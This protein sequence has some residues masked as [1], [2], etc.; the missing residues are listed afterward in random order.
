MT[1][2]IA[3]V[4]PRF[5]PD[6]GGV[7][8][9]VGQVG[10]HLV[11]R[12]HE[13]T[14]LTQGHP[15]LP[16]RDEVEGIAVERYPMPVPRLGDVPAPGLVRRLRGLSGFDVVHAHSYHALPALAATLQ[17]RS[18][19]TIVTPH[20]HGTGHTP[21]RALLHHVYRPLGQRGLHAADAVVADSAAEAALLA[22]HFGSAIASRTTVIPCGV[23]RVPLGPAFDRSRRT[24]LTCARLEGYKHVDHLIDAVACLPDGVELVIVGEGSERGPLEQRAA[25]AGVAHRVHLVGRVSDHEL[26]R[27]R[28]TAQVY[29]TASSHEAFGLTLAEAL[30]AGVP[31][32]ASAIPAHAEVVALSGLGPPAVHLVDTTRSAAPRLA[33]AITAA[34]GSTERRLGT[35]LPSWAEVADRTVEL[36]RAVIGAD[37]VRL[38]AAGPHR[39]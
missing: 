23:D 10:R 35:T 25:R 24:V 39:G 32:V 12:G 1:L 28:A 15:D 21:L 37:A 8:H 6:V 7:E 17:V 27:W 26:A 34:L 11:G 9:L 13:V 29:A 4:S 5:A 22:S 30:A 31:V 18:A 16:A 33:S 36:Y 2:R 14:V 38:T 19:P 20:Y 3:L